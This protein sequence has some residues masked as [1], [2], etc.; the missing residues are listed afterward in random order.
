MAGVCFVVG[1][2]ALVA[3]QDGEGV[4]VEADTGEVSRVAR[5]QA[6]L[7]WLGHSPGLID[8]K[9]GPRTSSAVMDFQRSQGIAAPTGRLDDETM[10]LLKR[11]AGVKVVRYRVRAEDLS[12]LS[13]VPESWVERSRLKRL[14]HETVLERFAERSHMSQGLLRKMNPGVDW[15]QVRAGEVVVLFD[16]SDCPSAPAERVEISLSAKT[17]RVV[18]PEDK[19]VA[20]FHC[21]VAEEEEKRPVGRFKVT[22]IVEDPEY[23][24]DP[25]L[26]PE[27]GLTKRLSIPPGPNNPVGSVW[28]GISKAGYGIHGT[29]DPEDV[30]RTGSHGCFRLTNWDVERVARMVKVGTR[31]T[32]RK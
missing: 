9:L 30:G 2:V 20:V 14:G 31:V 24:F 17:L 5:A 23:T 4:V 8:G 25:E 13:K 27:S 26:Y 32:I 10:K 3:A 16:F 6:A 18:G 19:T 12:G 7:D 1:W 15:E 28:I 29:P 22:T 11:V 21:S